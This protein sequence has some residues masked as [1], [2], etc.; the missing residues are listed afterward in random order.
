MTPNGNHFYETPDLKQ[1]AFLLANNVIFRGLKW[2]SKHIQAT[3]LFDEPPDSVLAEWIKS[4]SKFLKEYQT[5]RD[6]LRDKI[7]E[8]R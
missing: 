1:G 6:F 5:C 7:E 3:L 2:D 4:Q 8:E